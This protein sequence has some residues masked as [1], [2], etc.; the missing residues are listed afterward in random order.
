MYQSPLAAAHLLVLNRLLEH[1]R[2]VAASASEIRGDQVDRQFLS[3][4]FAG[5]DG[6]HLG[7]ELGERR[8]QTLR[9]GG[10]C[11]K[12]GG[13]RGGGGRADR[14]GGRAP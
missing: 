12:K 8:V 1:R 6:V 4:L 10:Y 14:E 13:R 3:F 5:D 2:E 9:D 7:I 11:S